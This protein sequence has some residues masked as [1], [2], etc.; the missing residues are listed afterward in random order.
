MTNIYCITNKLNGKRYVG[1]TIK[2][3]EH[4]FEAHCNAAN[5]NN[6]Y[7]HNAILKY[8]RENF[9][10]ELIAVVDDRDWKFW[11]RYYIKKYRSHYTEGGYNLTYGGDSNPMDIPEIRERQRLA[12]RNKPY[13]AKAS[14]LGR[15]H[16]QESKDK[17][18]RI[19]SAICNTE[20]RKEQNHIQHLSQKKKVV[21]LSDSGEVVRVFES[22]TDALRFLGKDLRQ[23]GSIGKYVDKFKKDGS[24]AKY[25]GY[26][27]TYNVGES[28][29]R[30]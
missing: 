3:I 9:T 18:S 7:I 14:W 15:H 20:E 23:A 2:P 5:K 4:R 26:S 25:L 16:S 6:M 10:L 22:L 11:E 28:N 27:W 19:Q 24:R 8:G 30:N 17:M 1:K 13:E 21:M 29:G 12:C